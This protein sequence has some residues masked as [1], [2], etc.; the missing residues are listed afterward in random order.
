[1][2]GWNEKTIAWYLR[3]GA[4][5]EYPAKVLAHIMPRLRP[6]H[7]VL[8]IGCGP[9]LYA[10]AMAP[11]VREVLAVDR[12]AQVLDT[13]RVTA[14]T[15]GLDNIRCLKATWPKTAIK[16]EAHV[17][18]SALGSGEIMTNQASIAAMLEYEPEAVFLIAP[19][20]YIPPFG[21]EREANTNSHPDAEDTLGILEQMEVAYSRTDI[22]LDFGQPVED[23]DE[24]VEF[25]ADFLRISP[26][27][28][29]KH[30]GKIAQPRGRD[31][32]LPNPRNMVLI[33]L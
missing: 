12:N 26:G 14:Q 23:M 11:A 22:L 15:R 8:D 16:D 27:A 21:T 2:R 13:L 18:I 29:R 1:M 6:R 30:A 7:T 10:L 31:L 33:S 32:Y 28:A 4:A 9:G 20:R 25:L 17:I 24:A 19:G 3:A 5:S